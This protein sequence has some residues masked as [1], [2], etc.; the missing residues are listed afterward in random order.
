MVARPAGPSPSLLTGG[1]LGGRRR[2]AGTIVGRS[3]RG[4]RSPVPRI[5]SL[6]PSA[7]EIVGALGLTRS[8]VGVS[9]ECD[10]PPAV[11]RAPR[12]AARLP[13]AAA[14]P[15]PRGPL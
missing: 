12:L 11:R 8:L 13:P 4:E 5:A 6:L 15:A 3:R 7:T 14:P 9:H 10:H 2:L 1:F